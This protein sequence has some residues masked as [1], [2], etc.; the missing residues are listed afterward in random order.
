MW[1]TALRGFRKIGWNRRRE[2]KMGALGVCYLWGMNFWGKG[3]GSENVRW[4]LFFF[5]L[6]FVV[7]VFR[8]K[9]L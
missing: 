8:R 6:S 1:G 9:I 2:N 3:V 4:M 7:S 5:V